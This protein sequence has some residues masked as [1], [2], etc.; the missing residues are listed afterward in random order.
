MSDTTLA[1]Y[2]NFNAL[3]DNVYETHCALQQ[4]AQRAVNLNLTVRNYLIGCYI[5]EFEQNGEDRAKYG[6]RLLTEIAK[7]IK[8]KGVKGLNNRTLS[9]CRLFYLSYP[10]ILQTVSA[11]FKELLFQQSFLQGKP[12]LQIWG[13]LTPKLQSSENQVD[14][15][16]QTLSAELKEEY[17]IAPET[18][19]SRLTFSHFLE[20]MRRDDPLERLFYEV[21]T[22]KN[23]WSVRQ[24]ERAIDT[25]LAFRTT[26]STNKE[27]IIAK[28]KKP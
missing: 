28:I 4:S 5:V 14:T 20:F 19:L 22:I 11:K 8:E 15:I 7:K 26:M 9:N 21:E 27:A 16:R 10:Q 17:P 1:K 12:V 24:L 18:L 3:V 25:S 6:T 13:S 2:Q 23:N